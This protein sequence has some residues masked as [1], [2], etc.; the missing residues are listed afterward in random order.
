MAQQVNREKHTLD[1]SGQVLGRLATQIAM[2]LMGKN[3]PS[4]MTYIDMGDFV[5]VINVD[6]IE[7]TGAKL[8]FKLYQHHSNYPGGLKTKKMKEL[9]K[10]EWVKRAVMNMLPKNKLRIE[11]MKR[12]KIS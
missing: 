7:V 8:D 5:D 1:A 3:K 10:T 11:R 9:S 6:K 12:L 2:I 4:Y